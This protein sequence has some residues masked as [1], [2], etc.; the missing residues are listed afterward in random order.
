MFTPA[1][2][3]CPNDSEI[4]MMDRGKNS[5]HPVMQKSGECSENFNQNTLIFTQAYV[6]E[7][8]F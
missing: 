1:P 4:N 8:I 7:S 2:Y 3:G 5:S 6:F